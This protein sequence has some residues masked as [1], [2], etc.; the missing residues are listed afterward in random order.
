MIGES[1]EPSEVLENHSD[2]PE[3]R[4]AL[5]SGTGVSTRFSSALGYDMLYVALAD[6]R[7]T[8]FASCGSRLPLR[9]LDSARSLVR[10][11]L[12]YG[13]IAAIALGGLSGWAFSRRIAGRIHRIEALSREILAGGGEAPVAAQED[14][15]GALEQHLVELAREMRAQLARTEA[16][17]AKLEAVLRSMVDGVVVID[18]EGRIRSANRA[19]REQLELS[20]RG[21]RGGR[22]PFPALPNPR[23]ARP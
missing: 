8:S 18:R 4:S 2:R 7:T 3:I 5:A 1:D 6:R 10:R 14:E 12:A 11:T 21:E 19:A 22:A 16:E 17:R 15:L 13:L 20:S 9:G 23:A